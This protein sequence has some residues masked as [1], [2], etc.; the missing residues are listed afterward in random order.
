M[1]RAEFYKKGARSLGLVSL[2]RLQLNKRFN[3]SSELKL[4][5]KKLDYPVIARRGTSDLEVFNQVFIEEQYGL[6]PD[7]GC[8]GL[9]VDLGANV[10]YSSAYFLSRFPRAFVVSVEPDPENYDILIRNLLP[11]ASRNLAIKAAAW[12]EKVSLEFNP[13]FSNRG[14]EWARQIQPTTS[15]S[16]EAITI[17]EII[18]MSGFQRISLLKIDIEGAERELFR[19]GADEWINRVDSIAI[20]LHGE[21][22]SKSFFGAIEN[23]NFAI[24]ESGELT[25]CRRS[26]RLAAS[27][28]VR[29]AT[30]PRTMQ[31]TGYPSNA[32]PDR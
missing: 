16:V 23:E 6:F 24:E 2:L 5:S 14:A 8:P 10:G 18:A 31:A 26:K 9:I 4:T 22:A 29:R 20:E 25:L 11:Y 15:G 30:P 28:G 3:D 17:S 7:E 21:E 27:R 1:N 32:P 12:S 13:S 19:S